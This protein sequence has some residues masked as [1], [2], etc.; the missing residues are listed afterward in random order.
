MGQ[1]ALRALPRDENGVSK[2][3]IEKLRI[4]GKRTEQRSENNNNSNNTNNNDGNDN[5]NEMPS[6]A[7][8]IAALEEQLRHKVRK[9]TQF[10]FEKQS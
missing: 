7:K 1:G 9:E 3:K 10:K 6:D 4:L 8:R 5:E 2:I